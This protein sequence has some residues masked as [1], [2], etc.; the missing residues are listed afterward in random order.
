MK[1]AAVR[2]AQAVQV[3]NYFHHNLLFYTIN[4]GNSTKSARSLALSRVYLI[5]VVLS[6]YCARIGS[7]QIPVG[8]G[9]NIHTK[10]QMN[11]PKTGF[12]RMTKLRWI[13]G[14]CCLLIPAYFGY[15]GYLETRVN[16]PFDTRKVCSTT[17]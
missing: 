10:P 15:L 6:C 5:I 3:T 13:A 14:F 16:T 9:N 7:K 17:N 11:K 8:H 4:H 12:I 1:A 2:E